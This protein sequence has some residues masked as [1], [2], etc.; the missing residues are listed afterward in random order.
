M[1]FQPAR[2]QHHYTADHLDQIGLPSR[3]E[4]PHALVHG[5]LLLSPCPLVPATPS[6]GPFSRPDS[7][8][9]A[10]MGPERAVTITFC[11]VS[12]PA[13]SMIQELPWSPSHVCSGQKHGFNK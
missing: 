4:D 1:G 12:I 3:Q 9:E 6:S 7:Q 10:I 2:D 11:T 13:L 8:D 5:L